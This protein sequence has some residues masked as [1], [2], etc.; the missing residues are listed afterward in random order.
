VRAARLQ[1]GAV[2]IKTDGSP[3]TRLELEIEERIGASLSAFEPGATL[4]GEELGGELSDR[5]WS[6]AVDP[7]DGTWA[8]VGGTETFSTTLAVFRDGVPMLGLVANPATGEIG[9]APAGGATR[10]LQLSVFGEDDRAC[11]LPAP[12][13]DPGPVLVNLH[14]GRRSAPLAAALYKAWASNDVRMVR[15]PGGSP[16]WALLEAAKG[17]FVYVNLWSNRPAS[18]YDLA[19]GCLLLQGAGGEVT[20]LD[21]AAIDLVSHA[22][23]FVAAVDEDRR[24]IV[25]GLVRSAAR[26]SRLQV[27][28]T[29]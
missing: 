4:V 28:E 14:P 20:D 1:P 10:L 13:L 12:R 6:V 24:R 9:Y 7:V 18:P 16:A 25:A 27:R 8:F 2:E 19:A 22:G 21:G 15:S 29:R 26:D 5:G 23:P 3:V 17:S 11:T